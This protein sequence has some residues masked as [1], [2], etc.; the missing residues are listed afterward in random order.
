LIGEVSLSPAQ[1]GPVD[2]SIILR[3]SVGA[4]VGAKEMDV[5]LSRPDVGVEPIQREAQLASEGSWAVQD[6][7]IPLAGLW[8]LRLQ[9]LISDF[10]RE[11]LEGTFEI[12][13][14]AHATSHHEHH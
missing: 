8:N 9:V 10:D 13:D 14:P 6:L 5:S 12:P 4:I 11:V 3:N 2:V 7:V 1:I